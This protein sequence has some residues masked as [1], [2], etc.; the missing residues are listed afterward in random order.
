M[1]QYKPE[2]NSRTANKIVMAALAAAVLGSAG[3]FIGINSLKASTSLT[4]TPVSAVKAL[5][6]V[7]ATVNVADLVEKVSPAVVSVMVTHKA[8][9][10]RHD[11]GDRPFEK[12]FERFFDEEHMEQFR[13]QPPGRRFG[14]EGHQRPRGR[15]IGSGFIIDKS[16][17]IVT[18]NHVI[19]GADTIE[20]K[21]DDG[22]S[23][24]AKL[25]GSDAKTDLA[26]LKIDA[27]KDL[28]FVNFG[29][30][31]K[32]RVGDWVLT[33]GNPFGIGKTATTGIVSARHRTIGAGPFD[34]FLQIDAPINKGNSGGPAFNA[35]GEVIGVNTAIFSPSGGNVGIGFAIPSNMAQDIVAQLKDGGKVKRG[36]LGVHIQQVTPEIADSLNL[37]KP[38]GALISKVTNGSPAEK[39]G[40]RRGDVILEV[41]DKDVDA[42]RDLPKIIASIKSG[43]KVEMSIWRDGKEI[44]L[45]AQIGSQPASVNVA[46]TVKTG[47]EGMQLAEL[48][49]QA[50]GALGVD[51]SVGGVLITGVASGTPTAK[52]GLRRGD[53]IVSVA[54]TN[55]TTPDDV[56]ARVGEAKQQNRRAVLML[57]LRGGQERFV[58]LPLK[59]A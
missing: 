49:D 30:S 14:E 13:N 16:G 33:L 45:D 6:G 51:Q 15:S 19:D 5:P 37:E 39:F 57:V 34:D 29:N 27:K 54:N 20:V 28:T 44:E 2:R 26:L 4:P 10:S 18:N 46:S 42:L 8:K 55:V 23:M 47:L 12:F 41:D 56:A 32:M 35:K 38:R 7:Q 43:E 25:V 58:A 36:W 21:L 24:D 48:D 52:T 22:R 17:Y 9:A 1:N 53:V 40:L 59:R 11:R 31:A 3:A 50:R